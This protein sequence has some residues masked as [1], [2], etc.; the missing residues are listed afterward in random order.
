MPAAPITCFFGKMNASPH[1]ARQPRLYPDQ[2]L[3]FR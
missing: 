1:P 2:G 3:E